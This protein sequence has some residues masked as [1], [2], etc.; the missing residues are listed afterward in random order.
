MLIT[1]STPSCASSVR[2]TR[3]TSAGARV[4]VEHVDLR[5]ARARAQRDLRRAGRRARRPAAARRSRRTRAKRSISSSTCDCEWSEHTITAWS[6]RN[7]S[8]PA[9]GVHHPLDLPVGRRERRRP[10]RPARACA[11]ACRCRAGRAAG[12]RTGRA[13]P[14]TR[15]RSR[16]L[17]ADAG[18]AELRAA[19]AS[20][21]RRRCRRRRTRAGRTTAWR[22]TVAAI[23]VSAVSLASSWRWRPRYIRYVVPAVRTSAS[24]SV[25]NTVGVARQV[26]GVHVVDRVGERPL[27]PERLRRAEA[28]PVLDVAPLAAVVPVHRRDEVAVGRRPV[29]IEAAHTGVTEGNAATHSSTWCPRS[30][31]S[32]SAGARPSA[33]ARSSI[34]GFMASMTARTSFFGATRLTA[35]CAARRT[36]R[37]RG[38]DRRPAATRGR[39]R[40][41]TASGGKRMDRPAAPTRGALAVDAAA[42]RRPRRPAA[43]A[44]AAE[45]RARGQE[46]R[47]PRRRPDGH[48]RAT[49]R[50][51]GRRSSPRPSARRAR[52]ASAEQRHAERRRL[53]RRP[54]HAAAREVGDHDQRRARR[55]GTASVSRKAKSVPSK[56]RP[57]SAGGERAGQEDRQERPDADRGGHA[58]ALEEIEEV[59][60]ARVG[61]RGRMTIDETPRG[62]GS[63]G[64]SRSMGRSRSTARDLERYA[65][66]FARA[67]RS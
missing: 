56:S 14:G 42:R 8:G 66:L 11:S 48:A 19:A 55:A 60:H 15:R 18:Q 1:R 67:R 40:R 10:A 64:E 31:S 16:V 41:A 4:A 63:G 33:T 24:S 49:S 25:S 45:Q 6:S 7:A 9:G 47:A 26:L 21:A 46:A 43:R 20:A 50:S 44:H 2:S 29:A 58:G 23:R 17:V 22:K 12:S 53:R 30:I 61:S 38:G 65:G 34:A 54:A 28:R 59:V 37:R 3:G 62:P 35:G 51:C 36:S 39:R 27:E 13:R 5:G 52:A 57:M 32:A